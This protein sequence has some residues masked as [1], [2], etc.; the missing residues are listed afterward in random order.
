LQQAEQKG[1]ND[2]RIHAAIARA[3]D[4][5]V[6]YSLMSV[7]D[8]MP[9]AKQEALKAIELDP[10][11][12]GG[13]SA[14]AVVLADYDW[15][16]AGAEVELRKANT[17]NPSSPMPHH[18]MAWLLEVQGRS[19]EALREFDKCIELDPLLG[20]HYA[21]LGHLL[22]HVGRKQEAADRFREALALAPNS[23]EVHGAIGMAYLEQEQYD[24]AIVEFER[25]QTLAGSWLPG[26]LGFS[27][28][29]VG[30]KKDGL[31]ILRHLERPPQSRPSDQYEIAVIYA[32][33][34]RQDRAL[35]Y[36]QKAYRDRAESLTSLA[37]DAAFRSLRTD[38]RFQELEQ[39][40]GV[41]K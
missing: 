20:I 4:W 36:L 31:A 16:W 3:Y 15:D 24:N 27:Y 39:Q 30:R 17:L 12:A 26:H 11:F 7:S 2:A 41:R 35:E 32:G 19:D 6:S 29:A 22:V 25:S 37:V 23:P 10:S 33:L 5:M 18:A 8:G 40:V 38:S 13:H 9:K 14:L 34:G 21:H 28:L 1:S